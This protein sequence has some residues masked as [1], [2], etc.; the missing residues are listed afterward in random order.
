M[1]VCAP[2]EDERTTHGICIDCAADVYR[3]E[4][5]RLP[6]TVIIVDPRRPEV[7]GHVAEAFRGVANVRVLVDRRRAERRREQG[8]FVT[9]RRRAERRRSCLPHQ[10]FAWRLLGICVVA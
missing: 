5:P 1:G 6:S 8:S 4:A 7:Y 9:D 10:R 2:M 3:K